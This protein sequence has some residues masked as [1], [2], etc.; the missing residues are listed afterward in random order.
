MVEVKVVVLSPL[1]TGALAE[2]GAGALDGPTADTG[3]EVAGLE[4]TGMVLLLWTGA[5]ALLTEAIEKL[6][7]DAI[8]VT[9]ADAELL[10]T[11]EMLN[12]LTTAEL[13]DITGLVVD[14]VGAVAETELL[15]GIDTVL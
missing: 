10:T 6:E 14:A 9:D 12:M 4:G 3:L 7:A 1:D 5:V 2:I 11:A 13:L 8:E 15:C